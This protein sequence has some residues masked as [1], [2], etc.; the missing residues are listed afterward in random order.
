MSAHAV[1]RRRLSPPLAND[2]SANQATPSAA[3]NNANASSSNTGAAPVR[4]A[5][6]ASKPG[7]TQRAKDERTAELAMASG[8]YK[9]GFFKLQ[10]D[11]LVSGLRINYAKR[12]GKVQDALQ[13]IKTAIE[14]L[15]ETAPKSIADAEK[16]L[17]S[18][19]GIAVPWPEPRP[20]K[21]VKY[22]VSYAKPSN[23]NVVG[24]FGL[25]TGA[26]TAESR[27]VDLAVTMPS[28]SFQEKDYVNYR[29]FHKRAYYIACLAAGI[30]DTADALGLDVKFH[31]QDGD[32]LRPLIVLDPRTSKDEKASSTPQI[33]IMTA[34]DPNFFPLKQ[35]LP[36]KNNVRQGTSADSTES[37]EPTP[38]YN[39][40]LRSEAT[41]SLY[42]KY[43]YSAA[44]K[45]E[46]FRDACILGRT[47]LQQRGFRTSFQKG[48]FGG[49]E[50]CAL[51]SL[52]FEGG[53]PSGQPILLRSYS[54]Y[55]IFK[56]TLQF[57][58]GRDLTTPLLLFTSDISVP[59]GGPV[60][61]DGRRGL[62]LLY[63]MTPWSYSILRQEATVTLKMLNESRED[64]F[65]KVFIVK[66]DEPALRF[67][68]LLTFPKSFSGDTLRS[69]QE[70][71]TLHDVLSRALGDRIKLI[72]LTSRSIDAWALK[73][74]APNKKACHDLTAGLMLNG[75]NVGRTVDHGPAAEEKGEAASFQKAELRRFKDGS[76]VE[77]LV[78]SDQPDED[79]I[80]HQILA[81]ILQRHFKIDEDD[82]FLH[83]DEY[84]D[85]LYD[86]G[87]E[88]IAYSSPAF[89]SINEAFA[90]LEQSLRS[91]DDVPLSIRH[92]APAS[93]LLRYTALR[94]QKSDGD[95]EAADVVLQFESSS[96]WPDDFAA[97]QMTKAAF[98]VKIGDSLRE[99]GAA[100]SCRV[101]MEN[102]SSSILNTFY[103]D[104]A[105][106]SG[107][108]FRLRIHH[109]REQT[110]LER[111]LKNKMISPREREE[112]AFALSSYKKTFVQQPRLTQSLRS[113]CTRLPLLSPT[114]RL[115][116]YW[117][118]SHLFSAQISEELIE[119]LTTRVF[120][121]P[122]PWETP[123]SIMTGFLRTIYFISRWDWQQEPFIVDLS[124][125]LNA[126]VT[127]TIKT[128][129]AA[130][131]NID[132]GMNTIALFVASDL[133]TEGVTW[134][135][136][137][138][139]TKVVAGRM[140]ALAKAAVNLLRKE[141]DE[142]DVAELFRTSLAPYDFVAYLRPKL[143]EDGTN[144]SSKYKN[145]AEVNAHGRTEKLAIIKSFV[146]DV[147]ACYHQSLL[148]FHGDERSGVVAGLW[149]PQ[150]L[151]PKSWNLK[152]A[153]ST[154]PASASESGDKADSVVI[155]RP[156]IL[157]EIS[158][159]GEG[160]IEKIEVSGSKL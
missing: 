52:L 130:W 116:K 40:S 140:T 55:Q 24:S 139:P 112:A 89:K 17:R 45:C 158:R 133:D 9:S 42:H 160:L 109:D 66:V 87:D 30:Q 78:W 26:K 54:S 141:H 32:S 5:D 94:V 121:Q 123:S 92:V 12:I 43:L 7:S 154:A 56:A 22:T 147:Q 75:E 148:L 64:N 14:D 34:F 18:T 91:M 19:A 131:R 107:F 6:H 63:K 23:I 79:S 37:G 80:V 146:K 27:P 144:S 3:T 60:L 1:K 127:E 151:K 106:T 77:S 122:Y 10:I 68:R 114:V 103:L 81:H 97:I 99:A 29:Y 58:A 159:L 128:R 125:D 93:A 2:S 145:L 124:G 13:K 96:R 38:Y 149:N 83:G 50:W 117:F 74:K 65:D 115:V 82:F 120:T 142:L 86:E 111:Q 35:T 15:P 113:L 98:L 73:S 136:Y 90:E 135:Q 69:L 49:F 108:T 20:S 105:H 46:A 126:E 156:A 150:M 102:E 39:A 134:T 51:I 100:S 153:Y 95:N 84:D 76:I 41:V 4:R 118:T 88:V 85:M 36:M 31:F 71:K 101:G 59:S 57:L 137:E 53:G 28:S 16:D 129:F 104:I 33:R 143:L 47:W 67:D 25:R 119:L 11:E 110:L 48:G 8:F 44:Q 155:N 62:N 152:M 157:N 132:P 61:F 138:M 21:D 70:Q 72:S